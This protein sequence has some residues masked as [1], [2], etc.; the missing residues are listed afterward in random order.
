MLIVSIII[1]V[2]P[3]FSQQF[4]SV[5]VKFG[6]VFMVSLVF[7]IFIATLLCAV[8]SGSGRFSAPFFEG[9]GPGGATVAIATLGAF[10]S[11]KMM[12]KRQ[13]FLILPLVGFMGALTVAFSG[14]RLAA[15][16]LIAGTLAFLLLKRTI[17]RLWTSLSVAVGLGLGSLAPVTM[18]FLRPQ[19]TSSVEGGRFD[20]PQRKF[21]I[22]VLIFGL[23]ERLV[24]CH[25][26][27]LMSSE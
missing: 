15:V 19:G 10:A 18:V 16:A 24:S 17:H 1:G 2:L 7:L 13:Q 3:L 11:A 6:G 4:L 22:L 20:L 9:P 12:G 23:N 25:V 5:V 14:T 21:P 26:P 27:I 8:D